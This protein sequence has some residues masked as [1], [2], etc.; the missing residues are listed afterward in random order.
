MKI[1]KIKF[2]SS[3]VHFYFDAKFDFISSIFP[4]EKIFILTDENIYKKNKAQFF[5]YKTIVIKPGENY[6]NLQ[7]IENIIKILIANNAQRNCFL[8]GVGGGVITDITGFIASTFLRGIKFGFVPTSLLAMVDASIGGKNGVDVGIYKN[9]IGVINQ[10]HFIL[11]DVGFLHS[12][13]KKEWINGFA[14]IIKHSCIKNKNMFHFLQEKNVSYFQ[15]N[16]IEL[17]KLIQQNVQIK[18]KIVQKDEFE[19]GERKLLNFG[20][21]IGHA[22]ENTFK[23]SHGNAVSIGMVQ[24]AHISNKL[25]AFKNITDLIHLL[26]KYGLKTT[27]NF[28]I[29]DIIQIIQ[30]DKKMLDE[31]IQFVLLKSIGKGFIEKIS[32]INLKNILHSNSN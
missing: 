23:I 17:A 30:K 20:H 29:D 3:N 9:M 22:I 28:N 25:A 4:T 11:Y 13:P 15:N 14:E 31:N 8:I 24:A 32:L 12:L 6:K 16:L 2:S 19:Q 21:T 10:P 26:K 18:I 27:I 5:N 1:Q 7:T